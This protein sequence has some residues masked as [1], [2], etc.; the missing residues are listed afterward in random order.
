MIVI[1]LGPLLNHL[2][3]VYIVMTHVP[4]VTQRN[5]IMEVTDSLRR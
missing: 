3:L 5:R 1:I 2:F 4:H